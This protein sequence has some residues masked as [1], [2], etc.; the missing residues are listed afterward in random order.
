V[1]IDHP[2]G[3]VAYHLPGKNPWLNEYSQRTGVPYEA[4]RGGAE[5]MYP[6]YQKKLATMPVPPPLPSESSEKGR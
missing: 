4:V 2:K 6:E 1:E 5:T 3:W